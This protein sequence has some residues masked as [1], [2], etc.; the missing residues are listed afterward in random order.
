[1]AETSS[2][3][4]GAVA[5]DD[6]T[7]EKSAGNIVS[8]K[9][10]G[11][12][13]SHLAS[14]SVTGAKVCALTLDTSDI[15]TPG[16]GTVVSSDDANVLRMERGVVAITGDG[17]DH[18]Y[19]NPITFSTAFGNTPKVYVALDGRGTNAPYM[20]PGVKSIMTSMATIDLINATGGNFSSTFYV[21]WV[22]IGD[23][24]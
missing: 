9:A 15:G 20:M 11:I 23:K 21:N 8:V 16:V 18:K 22:A 13:S 17:S 14:N 6:V 10:S 1:M 3:I 7:L 24:A 2:A 5:V 19:D 12:S 4:G